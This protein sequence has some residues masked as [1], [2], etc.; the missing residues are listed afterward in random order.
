[1]NSIVV[2]PHRKTM[3]LSQDI[4]SFQCHAIQNRTKYKNQNR[5]D[6][7]QKWKMKGGKGLDVAPNIVTHWDR[8]SRYDY[9][10]GIPCNPNP[11]PNR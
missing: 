5:S 1:M 9:D 7:A 2:D 8:L 6:K 4:A 10:M 11:N 3:V